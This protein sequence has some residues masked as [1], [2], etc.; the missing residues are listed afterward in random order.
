MNVKDK[1]AIV[2]GG[3]GVIGRSIAEVLAE[4][5][6]KAIVFDLKQ[7]DTKNTVASISQKGHEALAV[8]GDIT[9]W[10]DVQNAVDIV[11]ERFGRVDILINNAAFTRDSFI[12][13]MT[14]ED[15]DSV[16]NNNLKGYWL[17]S[18]AVLKPMKL[19]EHG[20]ILNIAAW[21]WLGSPCQ[22]NFSA[23]EGAVVSLTRT[24][25][26][27]FAKYYITVNAI[28]PGLIDTPQVRALRPEVQEKLVNAQPTLMV[29]Q[30][31]D[32]ANSVLFLASEEARYITGQ[33]LHVDGG[34]SLGNGCI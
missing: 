27:E 32:V 17:M 23:A 26:L 15:F 30:P 8:Q 13:D 29:G 11:M 33:V 18:K 1:I 24:L 10:N 6:A 28:A 19:Q 25:A 5:G 22:S 21:A 2:T 7:E 3:G 20:R 12:L 9:K 14:E 16:L 34:K 31:Y 4:N